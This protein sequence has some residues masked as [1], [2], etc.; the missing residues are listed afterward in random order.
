MD[1]GN[2][3]P[4][5]NSMTTRL[6]LSSSVYPYEDVT[7]LL[8]TATKDMDVGQL[9]QVP[10]FSLFDAMCAIVIMDPKMDTGMVMDD[11]ASRPVFDINKRVT[12]TEFIWI[13]D[14]ILIGQM[15]WLSGHALSQT[16]FTSCHILRLL[17]INE[18]DDEEPSGLTKDAPQPPREF[19]VA[20]LKSC[21]LAIAKSCS[22]IWSEMRKGQV[23]E[24]EDF[25][26]NKFGV[27][28][29][30]DI[31]TASLVAMLD[32]AEY[33]METEGTQWIRDHCGDDA[34][35]V[36]KGVME[37]IDYCRSSYMA[38]FQVIA[39]KCSQYPQAGPQLEAMRTHISGLKATHALGTKV[40]GAFDYTIHRQLV[41]NTPPR[42]IALLTFDETIE[43]LAQMCTD[44]M[45]IGKALPFTDTAN[46]VNFFIFFA[47]Q[48]PAPGAFPRSILQTVLYEDR[49]VMGS[50]KVEDV[51][52][53]SIQ[54]TVSPASWIFDNFDELQ[55]K[56]GGAGNT[57]PASE[58]QVLESIPELAEDNISSYK[59]RIQTSVVMFV[60]KATKPFVDTLQIMGQNTSRQR[61]NL[62]KIVQLWETLQ[63]QA[64]V[65]DADVHAVLE[66]MRLQQQG[67]LTGDE[68]GPQEQPAA[69][70]Y[71]VSW[72]Y[73][74][75]LWVME[76]LLLLGSE[77]ELY[78]PFEYSMVYAYVDSVLGAHAQHLQRIRSIIQSE[79]LE[80]E[81]VEPIEPSPTKEAHEE[82]GIKESSEQ[83]KKKKKKKKPSAS[84]TTSTT[85]KVIE[86][87]KPKKTVLMWQ[88][89]TSVKMQLTRGVFLV[90]AS[91]TKAGHLTTSPPHI[92]SHGLNDLE[93][94]FAHR[95]RAFRLLSSPEALTFE[96]FLSRLDCDGLDSLAILDYA[97]DYFSEAQ[98]AL[99][100]LLLLS[101]AEA[102]V[103]LC[104]D[105]WRKDVKNMIKVCIASKIGIAGLQKDA[106]ML[107]LRKSTLETQKRKP[108]A[109][110]LGGP[111]LTTAQI[112]SSSSSSS[113][114]SA[115]VLKAPVRKVVF[116]WKYHSWWPVVTLAPPSS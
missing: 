66:E 57:T 30:E 39:P 64:E 73:H 87:A 24:E 104:E 36:L 1:Q 63:E 106:R 46:L 58:S 109:S 78:S 108:A 116:E 102:Q 33:W 100:Q 101:A 6:S 15:T 35:E 21:V 88:F 71:F 72:V 98:R 79:I 26:T 83:K 110:S 82:S 42:A 54:E 77:L 89:L 70:F 90:L 74:M 86:Y 38:L 20:V 81:T 76:W 55:T 80:P 8:D 103:L 114:A 45:S 43:Q 94:L 3:V 56:L 9:I 44:L 85:E 32:Q 75:K 50:C 2:D 25:M 19:L 67:G 69:P 113:K 22:L 105:A 49:I 95:F 84:S 17:E 62:R 13:F 10:S 107:E 23:Y 12:P 93:T 99:D 27:S 48:K 40:E 92:A 59:L 29:F 34:A 11:I 7:A 18:D 60:E 97:T 37:R 115:P 5:L 112:K 91:L 111:K 68:D 4:R 61:R 16:L 41:A 96:N 65:F 14:N 52:R 28:M 47:S 51:V 31:P 53:E